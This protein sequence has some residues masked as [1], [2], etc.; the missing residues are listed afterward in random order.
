M[1]AF[2][3]KRT[4]DGGPSH[5]SLSSYDAVSELGGKNEAARVHNADRRCGGYMATLRARAA[6]GGA[7]DRIFKRRVAW[8]VRAEGRCIPP[9]L[10]RSRLRRRPER[11]DRKPLGGGAIRSITRAG[12]RSGWPPGR[13]DRN[14]HRRR[15][16]GGQS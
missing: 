9:R 8:A 2:D 11:G 3:P 5:T 12:G 7:G 14:L 10:E 1:S 13:G 6:A 16:T 15:S 4:L